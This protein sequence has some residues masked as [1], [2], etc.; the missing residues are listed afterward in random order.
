MKRIVSLLLL[1]ALAVPFVKAQTGNDWI[2]RVNFIPQ[3]ECP[4]GVTC[5][6]EV[7]VDLNLSMIPDSSYI[8]LKIGSTAGSSDIYSRKY[9]YDNT[10]FQQSG[11][12]TDGSGNVSISLGRYITGENFYVDM[13]IIESIE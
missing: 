8:W 1:A 13:E 7:K 12:T 11:V 9:A 3:S 5:P 10:F 6:S 4:E 2:Y